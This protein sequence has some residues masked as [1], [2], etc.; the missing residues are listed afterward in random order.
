M[1]SNFR[2]DHYAEGITVILLATTIVVVLQ[3]Y[4]KKVLGEDRIRQCHEVGGHYLAIVGG[5]YAVL[6][7]LIVFAAMDKF[8]A[9][10]KTVEEEGKSIL[11]VYT[12]AAQFDSKGAEIQKKLKEY[13]D[14][15]VNNEWELMESDQIS[16]TARKIFL[17]TLDMARKIEPITENQ[18]ALYPIMMTEMINTWDSRR[19]RTKVSNTGIPGAEWVILIIGAV[20]TLLLTFFFTIDS[21]GLHLIMTAMIALLIFVSLY[22]VLLFSDP[23]SGDM[24]VSNHGLVIAQKIMNEYEWK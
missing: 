4:A 6:L 19:D 16:M 12:M 5:F 14:E 17:G 22:L 24:R 18:K 21:Q 15:V 20:I 10:E 8:I 1:L 13:T 11:A 3:I 9:A 23:F 2:L 7:G